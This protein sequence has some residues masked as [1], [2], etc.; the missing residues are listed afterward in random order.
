MIVTAASGRKSHAEALPACICDNVR[1]FLPAALRHVARSRSRI[2]KTPFQTDI[3]DL[4]HDGRGVARREGDVAA[5]W[6]DPSRA[7]SL[8]GWRAKH[9]IARMCDDTWRWQS[10]NPHG[11]A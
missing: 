9:G 2:D 5:L 6:A 11:Y 7:E 3:L 4:S 10:R 8:L 1:P